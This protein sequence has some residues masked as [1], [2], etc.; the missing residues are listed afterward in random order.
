ILSCSPR[1]V[2][3]LGEFLKW[4]LPLPVRSVRFAEVRGNVDTRIRKL[5]EGDAHGL[6]VAKAALDRLLSA[7]EADLAD[8]CASIAKAIS[9]CICVVV[10][11]SVS[12]AAPAQGAI[13]I[14]VLRSRS[15]MREAA[16][17]ISDTPTFA[18]VS[19]ER[20]ILAGY[21]GGCH[22]KIGATVLTRPY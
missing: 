2:Y 10:P 9:Q 17:A 4:A 22:Q 15:D 6:I 11:L 19:K 12:P 21:G 8:A 16:A 7:T 3:N 14:E 1:R 5:L 18:A 20:A 13:A